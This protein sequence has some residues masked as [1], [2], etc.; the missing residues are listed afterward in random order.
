MSGFTAA[1]FKAAQ[2]KIDI[3]R[4][5]PPPTPRQPVTFVVHLTEAHAQVL[6]KFI[7]SGGKWPWDDEESGVSGLTRA[8]VLNAIHEALVAAMH[9]EGVPHL[10]ASS[11]NI[12][13]AYPLDRVQ[14]CG[15]VV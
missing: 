13:L 2:P 1:K 7:H 12:P 15:G 8:H 5:P 4:V 11:C 6:Q 10:A 9:A 3:T 14:T